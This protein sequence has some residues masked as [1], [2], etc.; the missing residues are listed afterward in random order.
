MM[1]RNPD[2]QR[3]AHAEVDRV[4]GGRWVPAMHDRARFPYVNCLVQ[5]LFRTHPVVPLVPHSVGV[6]DVYG[7]HRIPAGTWVVANVWCVSAPAPCPC[8]SPGSRA[9]APARAF[10]R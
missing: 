2:V 4:T 8:P 1:L 9:R 3:K 6:E 5:E 7:G 10:V